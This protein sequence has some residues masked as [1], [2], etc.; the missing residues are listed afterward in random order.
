[1]SAPRHVTY[2][3]SYSYLLIFLKTCA[4]V[5]AGSLDFRVNTSCSLYCILLNFLK[6]MHILCTFTVSANLNTLFR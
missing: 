1:M 5:V 4:Y 2:T 3:K 6:F